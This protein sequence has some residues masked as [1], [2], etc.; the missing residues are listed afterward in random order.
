[1]DT[2]VSLL[3]ALTIL[4]ASFAAKTTDPN[5]IIDPT[6]DA[7]ATGNYLNCQTDKMIAAGTTR[8]CTIDNVKRCCEE[9]ERWARIVIIGCAV[10][11]AIVVLAIVIFYVMWCKRDTV[12]CIGLCMRYTQ[13]KYYAVEESFCCCEGRVMKRRQKQKLKKKCKERQAIALTQETV[14]DIK[15]V[16]LAQEQLI[17]S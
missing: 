9:R 12:P 16:D 10:G 11:G 3:V 1:M 8:C 13:K 2:L 15:K 14:E 17:Q 4:G 6:F 5:C 7:I